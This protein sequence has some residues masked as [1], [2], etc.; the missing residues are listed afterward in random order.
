MVG[1]KTLIYTSLTKKAL[2]IS[3]EAHK[4]QVD[5]SGMPYVYHPF[6]LAE[7]MDD[8]YAVCV[9]LLHDVVEDAG[10]TF[11]DLRR[12]GF[13]EAV[14]DAIAMMTHEKSVPYLEYVQKLKSNPLAKKVKL[15]DLKH[16]S[17]LS[18]LDSVTEKDLERVEKYKKAIALLES[19]ENPNITMLNET[20]EAL[21]AGNYLY[22]G[23]IVSL[24]TDTYRMREARVYLPDEVERLC[25]ENTFS[26]NTI[27]TGCKITCE[28]TDSFTM[29]REMLRDS[30]T[31]TP[32]DRVLVLNYANPVN[33]GGGVRRGAKAQEEDLCRQSSLLLSLESDEAAAYYRYNRALHTMLGSDAMIISPNVEIIRDGDGE[34]LEETAVV[35]VLTC[36]APYVRDGLEGKTYDEYREMMAHRIRG[37]LCLAAR[38][39]YTHLVLGAWGCGAF[40]NDAKLI[41]QLFREEIGRIGHNTFKQIGF[42]VLCKDPG[43]Y[44]Y[45]VFSHCF[46]EDHDPLRDRIKGC[47]IGGAVGDA[48][49]YAIEF[50]DEN[51]IFSRYGNCGIT[52][53][54]KDHKSLKAI[55][56][57]DTQMTLFTACGILNAVTKNKLTGNKTDVCSEI[58]ASYCDWYRTQNT[59]FNLRGK[60]RHCT[61]LW[62]VPELFVPRAPGNTC[63]SAMHGKIV[64]GDPY[65]SDKAPNNSKGCGGVMRVAPLGLFRALPDAKSAA[66]EAAEAAAL[67]HGHPLGY[68]PAAMLACIVRYAV[69]ERGDKTLREI[70]RMS[71]DVVCR[72]FSEGTD[73]LARLINRTLELSE[74]SD[75]DLDNIHKLGEGWVGD[76]ALAIAL[77]CC[78][79]YHDDF[80]KCMIVSVNHKGDSDSTGAIAG[81]ILGA[82]LGYSAIDRKWTRDLELT[83]VITELTDDIHALNCDSESVTRTSEWQDKYLIK[84]HENKE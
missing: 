77:Y 4:K 21:G 50:L 18:R 78:L 64:K 54:Q 79:K 59:P 14:I 82:W 35:S 5:K 72:S 74:N 67:T 30:E 34:W 81:N 16:N 2:K 36:A 71:L 13:P 27:R 70:T 42:S 75:S 83:D 56:S 32:G 1:G 12:E 52:S 66:H 84:N 60:Y 80:D 19:E 63:L 25:V 48:L 62:D 47:L 7:Q 6:H 26:N 68:L 15:A 10:V 22:R 46:N 38:E 39:G 57:D 58:A 33:I 29:A 49:G 51:A 44:N 9:A 76:E 31:F 40:G 43:Q 41:A 23:R 11:D 28:N 61:W 73:S 69:F 3:F 53:Y 20:L 8:P 37:M 55:I 17:D 65:N 24:K 45:R